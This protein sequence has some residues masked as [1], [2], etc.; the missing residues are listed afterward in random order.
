MTMMRIF[1]KASSL[2]PQQRD[3][4][5]VYLIGAM[6]AYLTEE[7]LTSCAGVADKYLAEKG[8]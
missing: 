4:Y 2:T 7:E 6:S 3:L 8:V 5:F 1:S